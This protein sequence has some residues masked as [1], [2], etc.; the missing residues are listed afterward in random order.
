MVAALEEGKRASGSSLKV[1]QEC[2][3]WMLSDEYAGPGG[4]INLTVQ[5]PSLAE[6]LSSSILDPPSLN[7]DIHPA[8]VS[9]NPVPNKGKPTKAPLVPEPVEVDELAEER[10]ARYTVGGLTGLAWILQ[11]IHSNQQSLP[12]QYRALLQTPYLWTAL[13]PPIGQ[14]GD[15]LGSKQPTVR[16]AAYSL[17]TVLIDCFPA[18]L[19]HAETFSIVAKALI[20]GCWRE[21]EAAVW[22]TAGHATVKFLSSKSDQYLC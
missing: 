22:E 8:P 7:D 12:D 16:R 9:S 19:D 20:E 3:T 13:S 14:E 18:E 5:L 15:S 21:T 1:W 10:W 17:L 2:T 6:Y 11:Q 4:E